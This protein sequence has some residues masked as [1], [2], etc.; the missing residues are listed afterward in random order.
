MLAPANP[1]MW[2]PLNEYDERVQTGQLREDE[3]Q[4][5]IVLQSALQP[6]MLRF[7]NDRDRAE[8]PGSS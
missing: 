3:H 5:G 4:R 7:V 8:P 6:A 2:G 1:D